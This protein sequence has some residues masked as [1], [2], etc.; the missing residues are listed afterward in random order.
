MGKVSKSVQLMVYK[1]LRIVLFTQHLRFGGMGTF[2]RI[3]TKKMS[4]HYEIIVL[5]KSLEH[6]MIEPMFKA[7][8]KEVI[9]DIGQ[10]IKA[11]ICIYSSIQY[12]EPE[13]K[14]KAKKY[15]QIIHLNLFEWRVPLPYNP[16]IDNYITVSETA[17]DSL[18]KN[19]N[20]DSIYIQNMLDEP[21]TTKVLRLVTASRIAKG[22]GFER[23]IELAHRLKIN[24]I[25]FVWEVYGD[26]SDTYMFDLTQ[27]INEYSITEIN[28]MGVKENIQP[29]IKAAD[30]LVQLSDNETFCYSIHEALQIN[31]PVIVINW[32]GIEKIVEN[33]NN[34]YILNE[35]LSNL[36]VKEI[37]NN[38]PLNAKL[39]Y[40]S[41]ED[42]WHDLFLESLS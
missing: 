3:F 33:K 25:P 42:K 15:Y 22:K 19:F 18:K 10:E 29:Y 27:K 7:G 21:N 36:D 1:N 40:I 24:E 34:G 2:E 6:N 8:A 37:Y 17:R 20:K 14:V 38:I 35:D 11:D 12:G 32:K 16:K 9:Q 13:P 4:K 41:E 30:Y 39:K 5:A 28:F 31:L 26:G 23:M